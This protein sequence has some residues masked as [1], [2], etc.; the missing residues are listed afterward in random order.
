[1]FFS[2]PMAPPQLPPFGQM[3]PMMGRPQ[4]NM[5]GPPG[6]VAGAPM[7][8]SGQPLGPVTGAPTGPAGFP[9]PPHSVPSSQFNAVPPTS[10]FGAPTTSG[11]QSNPTMP[12]NYMEAPSSNQNIASQQPSSASPQTRVSDWIFASFFGLFGYIFMIFHVISYSMISVSF[13][14]CSSIV[15]F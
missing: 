2:G 4:G 5:P 9:Q 11:F 13:I 15:N 14:F 7:P 8:S 12:P 10:N 3:R 1:M 6:G